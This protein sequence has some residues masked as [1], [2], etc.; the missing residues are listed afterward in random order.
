MIKAGQVFSRAR[1]SLPSILL[2]GHEVPGVMQSPP[3]LATPR[4][5][6]SPSASTR[7]REAPSVGR[8]HFGNLDR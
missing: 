7:C 5:Q 6:T 4:P 1:R 2:V 3:T 8:R